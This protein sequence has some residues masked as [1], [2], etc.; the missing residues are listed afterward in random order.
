[1]ALKNLFAVLM[2]ALLV[3][4]CKTETTPDTYEKQ[5]AENLKKDGLAPSL[6][7]FS[8]FYGVLNYTDSSILFG[9]TEE[10]QNSHKHKMLPA[11]ITEKLT[12]DLK[13]KDY[14]QVFSFLEKE[15][16]FQIVLTAAGEQ[17]PKLYLVTFSKPNFKPIEEMLIYSDFRKDADINVTNAVFNESFSEFTISEIKGSAEP[18][19]TSFSIDPKGNIKK[20]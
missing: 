19:S 11:M 1:M 8:R 10:M 15:E 2:L 4:S 18:V 16:H 9:A 17:F 20:I 13:N 6:A 3:F 5:L 12:A 7:D 14:N